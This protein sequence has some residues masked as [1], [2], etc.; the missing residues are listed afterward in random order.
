ML[1]ISVLLWLVIFAL[2]EGKSSVPFALRGGG[3]TIQSSAPAPQTTAESMADY[4]ASLPDL[5]EAQMQYSPQMVQQQL[6]L[7]QQ[8]GTQF[9]QAAKDTQA[10]MYPETSALQEQLATQA[11]TGMEQGLSPEEMQQYRDIYA[12]NLGTNAGS[13]MGADYMGSSLM[14]ANTA[15]KDYYRNLGLSVAGRQPL[16]QGGVTGQPQWMQ[17]YQPSQALNYGANTYGSYAGSFDTAY[18]PSPWGG[19]AQGALGA[20]GSIV[21]GMAKGATGFFSSQRLKKNIKLWE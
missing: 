7:L 9:G 13:G 12:A 19:I 18:Q 3:T 17:G 10:A 20:V 1:L 14:Q 6:G 11:G 2:I 21:G 16:S 5:Y 8:Y 15:R 4:V